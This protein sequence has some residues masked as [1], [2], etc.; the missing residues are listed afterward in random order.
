MSALVIPKLEIPKLSVLITPQFDQRQNATGLRIMLLIRGSDVEEGELLVEVSSLFGGFSFE[1]GPL[2]FDEEGILPVVMNSSKAGVSWNAGRKTLG[3][4][5]IFY[6]VSASSSDQFKS[7]SPIVRL[8]RDQGG[9]LGSGFSFMA[10][11]PPVD[12]YQISVAWDLSRAPKK[13]RAVWTYGEGPWSIFQNGPASIL[14]NSV[15]MVGQIHSNSPAP[16]DGGVSG[17]YGYYWFGNL[18]RN[19]EAIKNRHHTFLL[20]LCEFF[21]TTPSQI[22]CYRSFVRNGGDKKNFG[23]MS[24]SHSCILDYSQ[25]ETFEYC[26]LIRRMSY[27][28]TQIWLGPSIMDLKVDWL[29]EG[30]RDC[31]SI[32]MPFGHSKHS[33]SYDQATIDMLCTK[34][35]TNP[36]TQRNLELPNLIKLA[37]TDAY[38][39]EH[40]TSRAWA[41]VVWVELRAR[42]LSDLARPMEDLVTKPLAKKK[43]HGEP[44]GIRDFLKLLNPLLEDEITKHYMDFHN[45]TLIRLF[46]DMYQGPNGTHH[47]KR[48]DQHI[49]D[50]GMDRNSFATGI[51]KGLKAGSR[52]EIAGIME[53]DKDRLELA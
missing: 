1:E 48:S 15:Y 3:D 7:D 16:T 30:I 38:A 8:Q 11:P 49:L 18:P 50:F 43:A 41:F 31:Q 5:M 42:Q 53:G 17:Y 39:R 14:R 12:A 36:L 10:S 45:G 27:E 9:L 2:A 20:K 52:A 28:M 6:R 51:V 24:F 37:N 26:D 25:I 47:L 46:E 32:Y 40:L 19:I 29:Y 21:E 23:T 34:Y 13:T 4:L 44:H 22:D 33:G 35:Y